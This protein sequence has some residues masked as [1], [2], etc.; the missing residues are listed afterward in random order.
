MPKAESPKS[1][2]FLVITMAT[3]FTLHPYVTNNASLALKTPT[4]CIL[5][6]NKV[7]KDVDS[8]VTCPKSKF[9]SHREKEPL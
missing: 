6:L 7:K 9:K 2:L 5:G 1:L 4:K 8:K 3:V